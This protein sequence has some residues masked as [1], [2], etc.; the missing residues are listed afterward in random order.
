MGYVVQERRR[1]ERTWRTMQLYGR[2]CQMPL[3]NA[4]QAAS[5]LS[6]Y[7]GGEFEYRAVLKPPG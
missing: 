3:A 6:G 5:K 1:G 2:D 7:F 4:E